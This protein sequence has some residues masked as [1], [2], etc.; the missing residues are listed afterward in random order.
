MS[1]DEDR[2]R[3]GQEEKPE[4]DP[5]SGNRLLLGLKRF[6]RAIVSPFVSLLSRPKHFFQAGAVRIIDAGTG[7]LLRLRKRAEKTTDGETRSDEKSAEREPRPE[8]SPVREGRGKEAAPKEVEVA[9]AQEPR[10]PLRSF[11]IYLLV[12]VIGTIA[13]M[14][15]SFALLSKM[16]FNQAQKI[17]DQRDEITQLEKHQSKILE[18]EARYRTESTE[19]QKQLREM[20][21]NLAALKAA[22]EPSPPEPAGSPAT[23]SA[24]RQPQARKTGDCK[25]DVGNLNG[26]LNR[27]ID[28]FNRK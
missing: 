18:S 9:V 11:F 6:W 2:N 26:N 1:S 19:Y 20:E 25:L 21:T 24:G 17:E 22:K 8:K 14:T 7:L 4:A 27:C 15:F 12:L 23:H 5:E 3:D 16:V 13:G 28:E 10:S